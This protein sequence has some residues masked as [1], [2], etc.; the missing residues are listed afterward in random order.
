MV[1]YSNGKVYKIESHLGDNVYY[2]STTKKYLSQRMDKHRC[3]YKQWLQ[4]KA[5]LIMSYKMFEQYGIENCKIIL[6]EN[7]PCESK[8]ELAAREAYYIRNFECVNKIVPGRTKKEYRE[9]NK[10]AIKEREKQYREDNKEAIK[11]YR[12]DNKEAI[13]QY[14][15]DNKEKLKQYR[16]DNKEK[17]SEQRKQWREANKETNKNRRGRK[18]IC[19]CGSETCFDHKSRHERTQKHVNFINNQ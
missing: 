16:E 1:N 12:E 17:I 18:Y 14:R 2:G 13:K 4:G 10:E 5:S 9:D 11:Q 6:I 7:C 19:E 8:D 15:E 3:D